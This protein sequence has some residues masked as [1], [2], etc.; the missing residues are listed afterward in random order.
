M[1]SNLP[2]VKPNVL[3][4][5]LDQ[6]RGDCLSSAGHKV[7]RTPHLDELARNGVRFAN[8]YS[9]AAPCSPGRASLY[10]GLYQMNHRVCANGTPLDDRFDNVAR[11]ATRHNYSPVIFGY[12]DQ[13]IDPRT[14]TSANDE[15]LSSY[16]HVLPGFDRILNLS[17][18]YPPWLEHL[19]TNGYDMGDDYNGALS[20]EP[21]RHEDLSISNFLTDEFF[22]WLEK[23]DSN[24]NSSW[25]SHLSYLRP[26]PPYAAA[27]KWARE[28]SPDEVD[29]PI[30]PSATRHL[31]HEAVMHS[32]HNAAP[33]LES[34]LR[35]M[36]TQYYGMIGEVD[37]QVGRICEKLRER[38]EW[39][40]TLIVVTADHGDQL[41]DHGLK[42]K[43]GFFESSY[44][45][46]GIVR[47]PKNPQAHGSVVNE[48]TE[49]VDIMPTI[50][51]AID[52]PVPLQCDGLPLGSFLRGETPEHWRNGASYEFDWRHIYIDDSPNGAAKNWPHD[53]RLE[54]QHLAVRRNRDCAYVQFGDGSW[55]AFD[56]KSDPTW[57]TTIDDPA[58]ILPLAQE[59]LLWRSHHTE[60]ILTGMLLEDG[61]VGRWPEGVSWRIRE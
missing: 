46:I 47:D 40:N 58:K 7:V 16:Q 19:I 28:Y 4:I 37:F 9:Q 61:G 26:H 6:F 1:G 22:T 44:H 11:L 55:L 24:T 17:E 38:G 20:T 5:T 23:R 59:M 27:G 56:L 51:E 18:P 53:R 42:D 12:T 8:H 30:A 60:R 32:G 49:N 54:R 2:R 36:R 48:F 41:G 57:R 21:D 35:E 14:T 31:F 13:G 43:L 50:A 25:F 45:I 15:R 33:K 39:D 34:E 10:T 52:A 3:L 29:L